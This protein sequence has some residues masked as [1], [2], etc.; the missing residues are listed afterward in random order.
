MLK[1]IF[2]QHS[3]SRSSRDSKDNLYDED[4]PGGNDFFSKQ[5]IGT[6]ITQAGTPNSACLENVTNLHN[7][8]SKLLLLSKT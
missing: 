6:Y 5:R 1:I 8:S 7:L 3:N 2:L 4:D